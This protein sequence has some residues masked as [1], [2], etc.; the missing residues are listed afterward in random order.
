M[1]MDDLWLSFKCFFPGWDECTA[2]IFNDFKNL[3]A[4]VWIFSNV[5]L[6]LSD[7]EGSTMSSNLTRPK[8]IDISLLIMTDYSYSSSLQA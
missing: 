7:A 2:Y 8:P 4:F 6:N 3:G 1:G 5:H